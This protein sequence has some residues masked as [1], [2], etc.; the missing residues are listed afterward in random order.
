[1][2]ELE[3]IE[4]YLSEK[5]K[6]KENKNKKYNYYKNKDIKLNSKKNLKKDTNV[7]FFK[8]HSIINKNN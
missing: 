4:N 7:S 3:I 1:M 6:D 2:S 8:I 5:D